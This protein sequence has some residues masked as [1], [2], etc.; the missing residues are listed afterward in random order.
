MALKSLSDRVDGLEKTEKLEREKL[1][2]EIE[3]EML[4][5]ERRLPPENR[6]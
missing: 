2:L 3:N 5:F 1:M 4:R 6:T